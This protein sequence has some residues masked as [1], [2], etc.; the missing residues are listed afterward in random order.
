MIV[1]G[2]FN[3]CDASE[4]NWR[5]RLKP[6]SSRASIASKV[7]GEFADLVGAVRPTHPVS[8]PSERISRIAAISRSIG[9]SA[10][11]ASA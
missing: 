1:S 4:M 5:S 10:R 7:A 8:S 3:S 9:S 11:E 6:A 2:V